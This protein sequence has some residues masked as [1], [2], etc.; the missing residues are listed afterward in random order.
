MSQ[1]THG[2][3]SLPEQDTN[4]PLPLILQSFSSGN[5]ESAQKFSWALGD[6]QLP[7][8]PSCTSFLLKRF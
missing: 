8:P 2:V 4:F 7:P 1:T 3:I 5:E 6:P